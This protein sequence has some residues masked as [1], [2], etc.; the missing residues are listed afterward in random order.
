M[1][2]KIVNVLCLEGLQNKFTKRAALSKYHTR[3][4]KN[5]QVQKLKLE[6]TKKAFHTK[7]RTLGILSHR[8]IEI[9]RPLHNLEKS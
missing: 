1:T 2:L 8:P 9:L 7:L 5:L 3:N 6:H 4:M